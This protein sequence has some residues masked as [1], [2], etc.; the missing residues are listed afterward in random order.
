LPR[1]AGKFPE[2]VLHGDTY[3]WPGSADTGHSRDADRTAG[4]D[5][6]CSL[7]GQGAANGSRGSGSIVSGIGAFGCL[8]SLRARMALDGVSWVQGGLVE[9]AVGHRDRML[10][11]LPRVRELHIR[12]SRRIGP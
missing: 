3:D 8:H 12:E 7:M 6:F 10:Q 2:A 5:R 9:I 4:V 11:N 1:T